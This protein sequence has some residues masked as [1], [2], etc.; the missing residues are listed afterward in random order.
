M[1]KE[2][3][4]LP[5]EIEKDQLVLFVFQI[6]F[7]F[8]RYELIVEN[9]ENAT[10]LPLILPIFFRFWPRGGRIYVPNYCLKVPDLP[11][12]KTLHRYLRETSAV[13]MRF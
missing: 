2:Y 7:L 11:L 4:V 12:G 8:T 6:F 13:C 3:L 9:V 5:F 1:N 10:T